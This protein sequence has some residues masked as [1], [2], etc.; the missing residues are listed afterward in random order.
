MPQEMVL[1]V[2]KTIAIQHLV[3]KESSKS[4]QALKTELIHYSKSSKKNLIWIELMH[5]RYICIQLIYFWIFSVPIHLPWSI[6]LPELPMTTK[7]VSNLIE[8]MPAHMEEI[9]SAFGNGDSTQ[10]IDEQK[11]YCSKK[12]IKNRVPFGFSP[13]HIHYLY[14]STCFRWMTFDIGT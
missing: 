14:L 4:L 3:L 8:Y 9:S 12:V 2:N 13:F 11:K 5:E 10:V 7:F 6:L 1:L